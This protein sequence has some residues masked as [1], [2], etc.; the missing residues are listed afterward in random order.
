M[1]PD[2]RLVLDVRYDEFASNDARIEHDRMRYSLG[3]LWDCD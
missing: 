2:L 3:V 1:T